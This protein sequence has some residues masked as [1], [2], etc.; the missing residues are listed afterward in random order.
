M[1]KKNNIEDKLA[2]I[3]D[4]IESKAW[5]QLNWYVDGNKRIAAQSSA[6]TKQYELELRIERI[7]ICHK[8]NKS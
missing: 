7:W 2:W 4:T 5:F 6:I 3:S 1:E 8:L